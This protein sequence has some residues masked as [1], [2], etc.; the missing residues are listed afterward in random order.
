MRQVVNKVLNKQKYIFIRL[1]KKPDEH[2]GNAIFFKLI[3]ADVLF[4]VQ[5][6]T[7]VPRMH[8]TS[9]SDPDRS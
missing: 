9:I 1:K 2:T 3:P 7:Y 8:K 6:N 5:N 4:P